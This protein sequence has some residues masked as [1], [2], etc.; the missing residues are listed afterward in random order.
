M[1][2]KTMDDYN[3]EMM[4]AK[5]KYR[6]TDDGKEY[7]AT[8]TEI[9]DN[10][11]FEYGIPNHVALLNTDAELISVE[12]LP[13]KPYGKKVMDAI[14]IVSDFFGELDE[15]S[16]WLFEGR[17]FAGGLELLKVLAKDTDEE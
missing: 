13:E 9:K 16:A 5:I 3:R 8:F 2:E 1:A 6:N 7:E 10:M 17:D 14:D 12:M 15:D 11:G 4:D